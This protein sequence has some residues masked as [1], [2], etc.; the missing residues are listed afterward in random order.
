MLGAVKGIARSALQRKARFPR[1]LFPPFLR[2]SQRI[3]VK[4]LLGYGE[5]ID[6]RA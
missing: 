6:H 2:Q 4:V 5:K 3:C 1:K